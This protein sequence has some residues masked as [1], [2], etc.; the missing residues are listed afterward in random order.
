M[1]T[2]ARTI[3][4]GTGEFA[5]PIAD[6]LAG[7]SAIDLV[8]VVTAP[9]RRGARGKLADSP[10][11]GLAEA[12]PIPMLRPE[13]LREAESVRQLA[14]LGPD[15]IVLADYG[16]IV[17]QAIL[18][19]PRHG[20]LNLH[21]SLLPRHRGATPIPASILAGDAE[22][23]VTLMLMDAGLDSGP[24]IAQRHHPMAG[25]ETTPS[26]EPLLANLAAN[27][28]TD[29]LPAWLAGT[30]EPRPQP[31]EGVTLTRMLRRE[32]GRVDPT[33]GAARL[34]RQVR[35]YQPWPGTFFE[36]PDGRVVIWKAG[37]APASAPVGSII[38]VGDQVPAIATSDG[39]LELLEVQP[40]G[41]RR[42]TGAELLRGRPALDGARVDRPS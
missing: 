39:L 36:S 41:G 31:V 10:V 1:T 24:I 21:P 34:E 37:I 33:L 18:D 25:N 4:L 28:L 19:L 22:T 7:I 15:L 29:V 9:Q 16:Q 11:A 8:A 32:D 12:R 13:R 17:P 38:A 20:A 40:A 26:L 30:I 6:A 35:A 23:G 5:V 42:M 27:L 3:F 2:P 14:E